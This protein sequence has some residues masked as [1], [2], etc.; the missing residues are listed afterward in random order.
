MLDSRPG[1]LRTGLVFPVFLVGVAILIGRLCTIQIYQHDQMAELAR[2][3]SEMTIPIPAAR[4]NIFDCGREALALSLEIPAVVADPGVVAVPSRVR[5][6]LP[7]VLNVPPDIFKKFLLASPDIIG[8]VSD[9]TLERVIT[10]TKELA[11]FMGVSEQ[12]LMTRL[13]EA[14]NARLRDTARAAAPILDMPEDQVYQLLARDRR[15]VCLKRPADDE[16][17][18]KIRELGVRGL[19]VAKEQRRKMA[20]GIRVGQWQGFV[21]GEGRGIDG[22]ELAFESR[23]RG[24]PGFAVLGRDGHGKKIAYSA[25]PEVPAKN[26]CHLRLTIDSR[27]QLILNEEV[28]RIQAEFSPVS[29]SAVIMDPHTGRILAMDSVPGLDLAK[30]GTMSA[31]E[32]QRRLRNHPVQS[33]YEPGSSFKPFIYAAALEL[34]LITPETRI[35]AEH[36]SWAYKSRRIHDTH[37]LGV[38]SATDAVADS[39]NICAAKVGL[40]LGDRRIQQWLKLYRFGE[41]TGI[42]LPGEEP[43]LVTPPSRWTYF[44]TTSV[45]FGQEIAVT[46]LQLATAFCSLINGG[47][48]MQPYLV[49]SVEDP[50]TG[51]ASTRSPLEIRRVISQATSD[52]M[53]K[54]L[55]QVVER[56][57]GKILSKSKFPIGGKTGTAQ[58]R[59]SSGGYAERV[60]IST[61]I[62]FSPVEQPRLCVLVMVDE[63]KGLYYGAQVAAPAV[64][65]IIEKALTILESTPSV[66]ASAR[67]PQQQ[68]ACPTAASPGPEAGSTIPA[69]VQAI[70]QAQPQD[71]RR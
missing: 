49:E 29:A 8:E 62:G 32:L 28:D 15:F 31:A 17:A 68:V 38:I 34:G 10:A 55:A 42:E 21:G 1:P 23:L 64:G 45:A 37:P 43:G 24:T 71:I 20:E 7:Q 39:S 33:V 4:G 22:L 16:C 58:K 57:T 5:T 30:L 27:L 44:T 6:W 41:R 3:Q 26:G 60:Y 61:F 2:R 35:N 46:P 12:T 36:G 11:K 51:N 54:I 66:M 70:S 56:G 25:D 69:P 48:L 65:R 53:R 19:F 52:K 13:D 40:M 18:R 59:D 63:P 50:N 67:S 47:R 14:V 9:P